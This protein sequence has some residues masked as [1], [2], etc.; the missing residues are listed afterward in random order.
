MSIHDRFLGDTP[1]AIVGASSNEKKFGHYVFRTLRAR[2]YAVFPVNR[3]GENVDNRTAYTSVADCP[4]KVD[5][6]IFVLSPENARAAVDDAIAAGVKRIWFQR[7]ADFGE[8]AAKARAAGLE[9]VEGR[10]ILMHAAPVRGIHA[11]HR[12]VHQ[13]FSK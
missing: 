11:V 8:A 12:C 1:T 9:T 6:A 5:A 13:L 10:C 7:G 4:R 3:S 2:G